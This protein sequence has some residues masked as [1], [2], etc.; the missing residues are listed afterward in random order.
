[1]PAS[2]FPDWRTGLHA[3]GIDGIAELIMTI[4]SFSGESQMP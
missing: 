3:L 4:A 1:L 2:Q